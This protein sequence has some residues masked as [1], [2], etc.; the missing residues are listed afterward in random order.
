M[1]TRKMFSAISP[2]VADR[3]PYLGGCLLSYVHS[4][5]SLHSCL[6]LGTEPI[7]R[8]HGCALCSI[9]GVQ[10]VC[11]GCV[12]NGPSPCLVLVSGGSLRDEIFFC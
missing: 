3:N 9:G 2:S 4:C 11:G 8:A 10:G 6:V 5:L 12:Q 1:H 7:L